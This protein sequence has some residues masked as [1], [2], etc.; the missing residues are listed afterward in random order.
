[1][2]VRTIAAKLSLADDRPHDGPVELE[3][4]D[5]PAAEALQ[6]RE[7]RAEVIKGDQ[8]SELG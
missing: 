8:D 1:M 7:A 4:V 2:V 3:L 5:G 6:G